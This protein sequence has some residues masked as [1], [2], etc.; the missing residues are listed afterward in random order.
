MS[1]DGES[2]PYALGIASSV[3]AK[4]SCMIHFLYT[5]KMNGPF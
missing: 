3:R 4:L 2:P 1:L 5:Q